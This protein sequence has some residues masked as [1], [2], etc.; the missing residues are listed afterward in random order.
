MFGGIG[1]GGTGTGVGRVGTGP[2][3]GSVGT[4]KGG[5]SGGTGTSGGTLGVCSC[6]LVLPT[7]PVWK[8]KAVMGFG[9]V[10]QAVLVLERPAGI[11]TV[12]SLSKV[13]M[14]DSRRW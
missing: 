14:G 3:I 13:I 8:E 11:E 7:S 9:F 12:L 6:I 5:C 10:G 2:G 1:S 4:G